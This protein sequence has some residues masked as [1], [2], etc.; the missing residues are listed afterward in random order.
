MKGLL[1]A[2]YAAWLPSRSLRLL[3]QLIPFRQLLGR[4][5]GGVRL[6]YFTRS[7]RRGRFG[8]VG[9]GKLCL[10]LGAGVLVELAFG[11]MP[12]IGLLTFRP[13]GLF[14]NPMSALSCFLIFARHGRPFPANPTVSSASLS[15]V[16][17]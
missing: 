12:V 6:L 4:P 1:R 8:L 10:T 9:P 2:G 11:L 5:L 7:R 15:R 14:P 13:P 3:V 16:V 17:R